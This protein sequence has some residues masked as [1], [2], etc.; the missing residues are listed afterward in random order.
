MAMLLPLSGIPSLSLV[1]TDIFTL[2][3]H[4]TCMTCSWCNDSCC[5][6]GCDVNLGERDRLLALAGELGPYVQ[7]P[8]ERW[9]KPDVFVDAEYPS[10]RFVRSEVIDGSCVFLSQDGRGCAIHRFALRTGRDYHEVKPMVCWLFPVCWDQAVL[11][12]SSDVRDDLVCRSRGLTLYEVVRDEL[13]HLFGD[14]LIGQL[15]RCQDELASAGAGPRRRQAGAALR[16]VA[17]GL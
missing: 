7:A 14:P 12:P 10:G 11:R 13:H 5:Q 1:D 2:K 17:P 4:G 9:F 16:S 3:M 8:A 6:Y 15:D